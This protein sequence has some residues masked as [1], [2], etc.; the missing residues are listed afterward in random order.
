[1]VSIEGQAISEDAVL[2]VND[3]HVSYGAISAVR[4][5]S[6]EVQRGT[7]VAIVG[8]NGAGKSTVLNTISGLLVPR[9]G[10]IVFD[11]QNITGWRAD[12]VAGLG[13]IQVPEGRQIIAPLSVEENLLLGAHPRR[14][15]EVATD[16]ED[17]FRRFPPLR[18]RRYQVAGALSGGEQQM[19]AIGRALMARPR[20][21]MLDEPSLGLAPLVI[22]AVF[23]I[24]ETLKQQGATILLVEQNARKAL[25]VADYAYVL[26]H[27]EIV[28]SGEASALS[29]DPAIL[30]AYLGHG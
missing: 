18:A 3:L 8:A 13:L 17:V 9:Q 27:G 24:V 7:V 21:L 29:Q 19:L 14:D 1:L 6:L 12:R 30:E 20:L 16:I 5:V 25:N 4:G 26:D 11:G 2:T 10:G 23:Q 28:R 22:Q 15:R